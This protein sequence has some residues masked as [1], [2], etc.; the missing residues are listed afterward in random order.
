MK[1][2][3][4]YIFECRDGFKMT[5]GTPQEAI[6]AMERNYDELKEV[7]VGK[8]DF[9]NYFINATN[10]YFPNGSICCC[11]GGCYKTYV[12]RTEVSNVI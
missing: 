8:D 5:F 10:E 6:K 4:N 3:L 9:C 11:I 1:V 7:A 2:E 12:L